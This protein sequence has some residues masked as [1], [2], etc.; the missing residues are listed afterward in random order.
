ME[1]MN[2]E[3]KLINNSSIYLN[4]EKLIL[5]KNNKILFLIPH[6]YIDLNK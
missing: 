3:L 1:K 6:K 2:N 4:K 5:N